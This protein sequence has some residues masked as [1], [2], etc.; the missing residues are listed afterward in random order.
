MDLLEIRSHYRKTGIGNFYILNGRYWIDEFGQISKVI[1]GLEKL[2]GFIKIPLVLTNDEFHDLVYRYDRSINAITTEEIKN[3]EWSEISKIH[4]SGRP[5]GLA[6]SRSMSSSLPDR[7]TICPYC[8]KG[9]DLDNIDDCLHHQSTW[10]DYPARQLDLYGD[11]L[12]DFVGQ[13][14]QK[15]WDYFKMR[16]NAI[17]YP[18]R[19]HGISNPK[20][21]DLRPNP[22]YKTLKINENGFYDGKIDENYIIQKDDSIGFQMV[23]CYHKDCNRKMLNEREE[24]KFKECFIKAGFDDFE[25]K[26]IPNEYCHDINNCTICSDWFNVVTKY[27]TIKIGWRKRVIYIEWPNIQSNAIVLFNKE[28]VTKGSNYI[29]AWGWEKCTEYLTELKKSL[30][31]L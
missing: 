14:L 18:M 7:N 13:P 1:D 26:H 25:M 22:E 28:D 15:V 9:W 11:V 12:W 16:S 6:I 19:E 2:K 3:L 4:E 10:K 5:F 24:E 21:I 30:K 8:G 17:Y 29:H 20:W 23:E 31:I 27:G